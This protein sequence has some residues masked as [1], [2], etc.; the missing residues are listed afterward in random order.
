VNFEKGFK[1]VKS[2]NEERKGKASYVNPA[3]VLVMKETK[4]MARRIS[5]ISLGS[6]GG[7][8][9]SWSVCGG[10]GKGEHGSKV[11]FQN[12]EGKEQEGLNERQKVP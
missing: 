11:S 7:K 3:G 10:H 1:R 12:A 8:T 5:L 9:H 4:N 2:V 6:G